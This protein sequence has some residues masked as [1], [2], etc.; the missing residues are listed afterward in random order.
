[1]RFAEIETSDAGPMIPRPLKGLPASQPRCISHSGREAAA[2]HVDN[3]PGRFPRTPLAS[4]HGRDRC[5]LEHNVHEGLAAHL[6]FLTSFRPL[7]RRAVSPPPCPTDSARI[8]KPLP[9]SR[10]PYTQGRMPPNTPAP[11]LA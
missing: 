3:V 4:L 7:P 6:A 1:M 2:F 8:P 5:P 9:A 11:P 10:T